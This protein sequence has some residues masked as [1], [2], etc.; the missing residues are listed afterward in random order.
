MECTVPCP[1][2][3]VPGFAAGIALYYLWVFRG[4][5]TGKPVLL[6]LLS[7]GGDS[8][9]QPL[10]KSACTHD[11]HDP[12]VPFR[13]AVCHSP[14]TPPPKVFFGKAA[15]EAIIGSKERHRPHRIRMP[16]VDR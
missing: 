10:L 16:I 1:A 14:T 15:G 5:G 3:A 12:I 9:G 11:P 4:A 2:E 8:C 7:L 6:A 13:E